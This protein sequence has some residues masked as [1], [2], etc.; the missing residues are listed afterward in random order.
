MTNWL[1]TLMTRR[2]PSTRHLGAGMDADTLRMAH[3]L[4]LMEQGDL[5]FD[6]LRTR[7]P[8]TL[9]VYPLLLLYEANGSRFSYPA[10]ALLDGGV[11][12]AKTNIV[13]DRTRDDA[14]R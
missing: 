6:T 3:E 4:S 5:I 10:D 1:N 8:I 2:N 7:R 9:G 11:L 12:G 14:T 13:D